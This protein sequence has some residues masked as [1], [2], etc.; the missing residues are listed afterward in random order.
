MFRYARGTPHPTAGRTGLAIVKID[1][2]EAIPQNFG[3]P[4]SFHF[5]TNA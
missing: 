2:S 5:K 4:L 1:Q 3:F